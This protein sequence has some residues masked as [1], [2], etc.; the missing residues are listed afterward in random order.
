MRDCTLRM[1][2]QEQISHIHV[3]K[4][5]S[6]LMPRESDWTSS[7]WAYYPSNHLSSLYYSISPTSLGH[8]RLYNLAHSKS[9]PK[10]ERMTMDCYPALGY[11]L[12]KSQSRRWVQSQTLVDA[13]IKVGEIL[14]LISR[15][16]QVVELL[17][18]FFVQLGLDVGISGEVVDYGTSGASRNSSPRKVERN[19]FLT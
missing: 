6:Y 19:T 4:K 2:C 10:R 17:V 5:A 9:H 14:H 16:Y 11:D 18:E 3:A 15:W 13:R 12:R 1:P 8:S 7:G